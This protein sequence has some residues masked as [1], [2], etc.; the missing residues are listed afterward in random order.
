MPGLYR[1]SGFGDVT[2]Y[3]TVEEA[4]Q[5]VEFI[6]KVF[7]A[8]VLRKEVEEERG[9]IINAALRIGDSVIEVSDAN[10]DWKPM[11]GA[12]HVYVPD[13]DETYEKAMAAGATSLFPPADMPYGERSAGVRDPSGNHWYIARYTGLV[14]RR[15]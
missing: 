15:A 7:D 13:V 1:P 6:V 8:E 11:P 10:Q 9:T 12:L 4:E 2:P 3:L 5:L 14:E